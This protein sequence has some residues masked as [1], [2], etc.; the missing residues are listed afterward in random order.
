[1]VRAVA[2]NAL[3]AIDQVVSS[4]TNMIMVFSLA[5]MSDDVGFGYAM[6][7]YATFSLLLKA[8]RQFFGVSISLAAESHGE[9]RREA[10]ASTTLS[11]AATPILG[12]LIVA[13]PLIAGAGLMPVVLALAVCVGLALAQDSMRFSLAGQQMYTRLLVADLVW[14]AFVLGGLGARIIGLSNPVVIPLLWGLGAAASILQMAPAASHFMTLGSAVTRV[15]RTFTE[16]TRLASSAVATGASTTVASIVVA[17]VAGPS[18]AGALAAAG[19]LMGPVSLFAALFG[20]LVLPMSTRHDARDSINIFVVATASIAVLCVFW[21][22]FLLLLPEALG[23]VLLGETWSAARA[24]LPIVG[25][26]VTFVVVG[27]GG[28]MLLVRQKETRVLLWIR[29]VQ[30]V[31][32]LP[33][34]TWVALTFGTSAALASAELAVTFALACA[35]WAASLRHRRML[36]A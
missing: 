8:S 1:M 18:V 15:R 16:R 30:S 26:S 10:G 29:L 27:T 11:L 13:G 35:V 2:K 5:G 14:L 23:V 19:Q 24:V 20:L 33:L 28:A 6:V 34:V 32:R 7:A 22:S 25:V 21:L 9:V 36:R 3:V 31:A 12:G 17:T 4:A